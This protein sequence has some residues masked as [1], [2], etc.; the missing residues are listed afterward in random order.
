MRSLTY[1]HVWRKRNSLKIT[2]QLACLIIPHHSLYY[3]I[4]EKSCTIFKPLFLGKSAY[5]SHGFPIHTKKNSPDIG[6]LVPGQLASPGWLPPPSSH[7]KP[8]V[9]CKVI[10]IQKCFFLAWNLKTDSS[11]KPPSIFLTLNT[12]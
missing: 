12:V 11:L 9:P 10:I 3:S 7:R 1:G 4:S 6:P 8:R 5:Y 2:K